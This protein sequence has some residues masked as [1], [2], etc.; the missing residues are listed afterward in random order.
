MDTNQVYV[1]ALGPFIYDQQQTYSDTGDPVQGLRVDG[2][3]T[4][5]DIP[6]LPHHVVRLEDIQAY[7][8]TGVAVA[9]I[10]NPTELRLIA[11]TVGRLLYVYQASNHAATLYGWDGSAI[12][13]IGSPYEVA[14]LGSNVRW[15]AL[16]GR[17]AYQA[18]DNNSQAHSFGALNLTGLL[19][20]TNDIEARELTLRNGLT[21]N[22][23]KGNYDFDVNTIAEA[24]AMHIDAFYNTVTFADSTAV[25][26]L[27]PSILAGAVSAST[28]LLVNA[29]NGSSSFAVN[30]TGG[31][32]AVLIATPTNSGRVG[33][34]VAAPSVAFHCNGEALFTDAATIRGNV[35]INDIYGIATLSVKKQSVT[36][37]QVDNTVFKV[38]TTNGRVGVNIASPTVPLDVVGTVKISDTATLAAGIVINNGAGSIT[39]LTVKGNSTN[40]ALLAGTS[41]GAQYV[42]VNAAALSTDA[43]FYVNGNGKFQGTLLTT[44]DVTLGTTQ[45]P[46]NLTV[47]GGALINGS[48]GA[49]VPFLVLGSSSATL[50]STL[51]TTVTVGGTVCNISS[52]TTNIVG[53][54]NIASTAMKITGIPSSNVGLPV[55]G[56]YKDTNGF[57]R[58]VLA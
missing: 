1:G 31:A 30:N 26:I 37:P 15:L 20:S 53:I 55:G 17:Y 38:D 48:G 49:G 19:T 44:G 41:G 7:T 43:T 6:S 14:A 29:A 34:N 42:S 10:S 45:A 24:P 46:A 39:A 4:V 21:V 18:F 5:N 3:M 28:S 56:I 50:F 57:L 32:T 11:G 35:I 2:Q 13:Q 12:G 36:S 40:S 9:N 27:G 58:I 54:V 33:I 16:A 8:I 47:N 22:D 25:S 51:A 23:I 52:T